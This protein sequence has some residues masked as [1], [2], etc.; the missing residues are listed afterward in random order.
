MKESQKRVTKGF[1]GLLIPASHNL[2]DN[3]IGSY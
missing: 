3:K 1:A 2:H